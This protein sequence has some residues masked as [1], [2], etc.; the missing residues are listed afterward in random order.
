MPERTN[1]TAARLHVPAA[2][3]RLQ[4]GADVRA[5]ERTQP[6]QWATMQ[7][8][9]NGIN[10]K[11]T[12]KSCYLHHCA[13]EML[14]SNHC[15]LCPAFSS[16]ACSSPLMPLVLPLSFL[17]SLH[18]PFPYTTAAFG[19]SSNPLPTPLSLCSLHGGRHQCKCAK[20]ACQAL[21][22]LLPLYLFLLLLLLLLLLSLLKNHRP[23]IEH[24]WSILWFVQLQQH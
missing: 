5:N 4:N 16:Y 9:P 15:C 19:P 14:T 2:E 1:G 20:A 11:F 17:S 8:M 22:L 12:C 18:S 10:L 21:L 13:V 6:A 7:Q 3:M 23:E 24:I